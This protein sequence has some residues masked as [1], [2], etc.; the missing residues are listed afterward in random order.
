[1]PVRREF[2]ASEKIVVF[3]VTMARSRKSR[4]EDPGQNA[5]E[6]FRRSVCSQATAT[7]YLVLQFHRL[8]SFARPRAPS[9]RAIELVPHA[10]IAPP[11]LHAAPAPAT[12]V[13]SGSNSATIDESHPQVCLGRWKALMSFPE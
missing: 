5:L 12:L 9:R 6:S 8:F 2:P 11:R 4:R 3:P 10:S 13:H 1:M 7:S